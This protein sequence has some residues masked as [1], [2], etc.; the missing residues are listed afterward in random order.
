MD[1]TVGFYEDPD[2]VDGY[3]KMCEGYDGA[4]I[5]DML[6]RDT[7]KRDNH[8]WSSVVA[9]AMISPFS[10]NATTLLGP[11]HQRSF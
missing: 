4:P 7:S 10:R 1:R 11:I 5:F 9:R 3:E 8:Y 6:A 2:N